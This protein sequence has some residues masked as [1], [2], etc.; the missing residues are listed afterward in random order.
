MHVPATNAWFVDVR[1]ASRSDFG[2]ERF[3]A[4]A[5][6]DTVLNAKPIEVWDTGTVDGKP[7][8][9]LNKEQTELALNKAVETKDSKAADKAM[10]DLN[11]SCDDCHEV[12]N[13]VEKKEE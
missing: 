9:T 7:T 1:T 11:Q 3:P 8:R 13:K 4:Y 2:T 10:S 12:F 5:I 6:L